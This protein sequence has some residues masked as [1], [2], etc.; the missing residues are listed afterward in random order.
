MCRLS[1]STEDEDCTFERIQGFTTIQVHK[2]F[3]LGL[4]TVH[5]QRS[6]TRTQDDQSYVGV[7]LPSY[8]LSSEEEVDMLDD[9][10]RFGSVRYF[11]SVSVNQQSSSP[12]SFAYSSEEI[13]STRLLLA[14][15][16]W[17][18]KLSDCPVSGLP[19]VSSVAGSGNELYCRVVPV[20]R[21]VCPCALV[22]SPSSQPAD[23]HIV[24]RF[25][26]Y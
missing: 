11:F 26:D 10:V 1:R 19:R 7:L 13:P 18:E 25:P 9:G 12:S 17:R 22:P 2:D 16:D 23:S 24:V 3:R 20:A 6:V 5:S 8:E 14:M 21:I 15:M 4:S